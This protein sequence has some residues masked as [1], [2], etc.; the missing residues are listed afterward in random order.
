[1]F[2]FQSGTFDLARLYSKKPHYGTS[3]GEL[4]HFSNYLN[5]P[6][7]VLIEKGGRL[8][9]RI[10]LDTEDTGKLVADCYAK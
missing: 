7:T 2:N 4:L 9:N 5:L 3:S 10:Y 8:W 6:I 1:M